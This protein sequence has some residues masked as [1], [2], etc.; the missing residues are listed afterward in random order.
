MATPEPRAPPLLFHR[1][2]Q[3]EATEVLAECKRSEEEQES[4]DLETSRDAVKLFPA[5]SLHSA[6]WEASEA[7]APDSAP[8]ESVAEVTPERVRKSGGGA[9]LDRSTVDSDEQ[10]DIWSPNAREKLD[11]LLSLLH[12]NEDDAESSKEEY[13]EPSRDGSSTTGTRRGLEGELELAAPSPEN[14]P[15]AD[16]SGAQEQAQP[17]EARQLEAEEA[18]FRGIQS[19]IHNERHSVD[20]DLLQ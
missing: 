2:F 8:A 6:L 17:Q 1:A 18:V 20:A 3:E 12:L 11:S 16:A 19:V 9:S 15:L 7:S 5:L 14:I 13:E 10:G 4:E